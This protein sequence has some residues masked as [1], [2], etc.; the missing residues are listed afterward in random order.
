MIVENPCPQIIDRHAAQEPDLAVFAHSRSFPAKRAA[1]FTAA[2]LPDLAPLK[3]EL[4]LQKHNETDG[5]NGK[6]AGMAEA[7]A[8]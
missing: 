6:D 2:N 5:Q 8:A 3:A 4:E 7:T 1:A